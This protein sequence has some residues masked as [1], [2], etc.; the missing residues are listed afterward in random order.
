MECKRS[1]DFA[2]T[3]ESFLCQSYIKQGVV[4]GGV[5]PR[6]SLSGGTCLGEPLSGGRTLV[7]GGA[8]VLP[9]LC[10]ELYWLAKYRID[11]K[12]IW[13]QHISV[14]PAAAATVGVGAIRNKMFYESRVTRTE[15]KTRTVFFHY[16]STR[17]YV[18]HY[19]S[20]VAVLRIAYS[21]SEAKTG[22][23]SSGVARICCEERAKL[24]I[25]SRGTHGGFQGR[26]LDDCL[27]VCD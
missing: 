12:K 4:W 5:C 27:E 15:K 17:C 6:G 2:D 7:W 10:T 18:Q 23:R 19:Y 26:V 9:S 1:K 8:F 16:L 24:E 25:M 11:F 13:H 14:T 22:F 3:L 20:T 21:R